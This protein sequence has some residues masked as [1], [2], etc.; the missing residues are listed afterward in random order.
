MEKAHLLLWKFTH[1]DAN[2]DYVLEMRELHGFLKKTKKTISPKKCSRSFLAYCDKDEDYK[3]S[4][5]EWYI[6]L[7]EKGKAYDF[8]RH[9]CNQSSVSNVYKARPISL[10][11]APTGFDELPEMH[12]KYL[13]HLI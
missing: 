2:A 5:N 12:F 10:F 1:L 3:L 9:K 8:L 6:C 7:G 4:L 13:F 11:L